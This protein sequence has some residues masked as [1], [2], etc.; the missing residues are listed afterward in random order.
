MDASRRDL[1][2]E[3]MYMYMNFYIYSPSFS[4][5]LLPFPLL[6]FNLSWFILVVLVNLVRRGIEGTGVSNVYMWFFI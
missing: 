2:D 5:S 3:Y 1:I 6:C 4:S